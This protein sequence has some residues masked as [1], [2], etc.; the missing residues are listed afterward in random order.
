M[1]KSFSQCQQAFLDA[2]CQEFDEN[3]EEHKLDHTVLFKQYVSMVENNI[4]KAMKM[5]IPYLKIEKM[6]NVLE[7]RGK[8]VRK[9][10]LL[11]LCY[12]C[13]KGSHPFCHIHSCCTTF[14]FSTMLKGYKYEKF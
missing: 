3:S 14:I 12:H 11:H 6:F 10:Y 5:K 7:K 13:C 9:H 8:E 4:E 1:E 2:H